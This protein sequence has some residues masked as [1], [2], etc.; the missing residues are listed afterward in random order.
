MVLG[1]P[2]PSHSMPSGP[3]PTLGRCYRGAPNRVLVPPTGGRWTGPVGRMDPVRLL[4]DAV[5]VLP[6]GIGVLADLLALLA[7]QT[8]ATLGR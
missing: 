2:G 3:V 7:E 5:V 8:L 6:G 1:I 4:S